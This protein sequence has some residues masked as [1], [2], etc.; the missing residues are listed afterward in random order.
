MKK[1]VS[2]LMMAVATISAHAQK[3]ALIDMEYIL[4]NVPAYERACAEMAA[5]AIIS[6]NTIFF[7]KPIFRIPDLDVYT[8]QLVCWYTSYP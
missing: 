5:T 4:K 6:I 1:I 2:M 8:R 7:I 3:Y